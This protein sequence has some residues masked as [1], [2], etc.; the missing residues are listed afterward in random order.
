MKYKIG[1]TIDNIKVI[2]YTVA[3]GNRRAYIVKCTCNKVFN[4]TGS[5]LDRYTRYFS[6]DGFAGCKD[7]KLNFNK[8][9]RTETGNLYNSIYYRYKKA[10]KNRGL[11]FN[12]TIEQAAELFSCNE[13]T[14]C[15]KPSTT[16]KVESAYTE[17]TYM[18]IDRVD[19][20][21]GYINGN[22]VPCCTKCNTAK[23]V[24]NSIDFLSHISDIYNYNLQ[25]L[26]R[27]LVDS[28]ESKWEAVLRSD[29]ERLEHEDIV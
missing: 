10:A 11:M 7:C 19:T 1:H 4:T 16:K 8:A 12:L 24:L 28:S 25:R 9:K 2:D 14:Y 27:R 6:R 17:Y 21:K 26:E 13:C 22:C 18:G 3:K 15:G 5:E 23:H 29:I 20:S